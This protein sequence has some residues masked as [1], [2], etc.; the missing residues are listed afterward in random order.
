MNIFDRSLRSLYIIVH[1]YARLSI[2]GAPKLEDIIPEAYP[3]SIIIDKIG[4]DIEN[5]Y[6][7]LLRIKNFMDFKINKYLIRSY[8]NSILNF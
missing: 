1:F 4:R 8:M 7:V 6:Y 5:L 3:R 2:I